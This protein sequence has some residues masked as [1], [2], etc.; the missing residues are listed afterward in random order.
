M[1][2][3]SQRRADERYER[4]RQGQRQRCC[5]DLDEVSPVL[6][7]LRKLGESRQEAIRRLIFSS[8]HNRW[9]EEVIIDQLLQRE[10]GVNRRLEQLQEIL[11]QVETEHDLAFQ[12]RWLDKKRHLLEVMIETREEFPILMSGDEEQIICLINLFSEQEVN[13]AR[14][15][16]MV[17]LMLSMNLPMPLSAFGKTGHYYQL[18][19]SMSVNTVVENLISELGVLSD[20]ALEAMEVFRE[21][22]Q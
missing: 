18:F 17:A 3:D 13:L 4:K 9:D 8:S 10:G 2:R 15:S 14:K 12:A 5:F 16:E 6:D 11:N 19:G 7:R 20:N 22:L 1:R 21:F